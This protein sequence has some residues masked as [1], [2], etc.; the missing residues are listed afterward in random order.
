MENNYGEHSEVISHVNVSE[1]FLVSIID[2]H[3]GDGVGFLK[4]WFLTQH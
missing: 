3:E 4:H 1:I 2:R